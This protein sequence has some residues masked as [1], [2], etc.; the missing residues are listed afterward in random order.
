M[1]EH[2]KM[3]VVVMTE[4]EDGNGDVMRRLRRRSMAKT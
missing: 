2:C 1:A 4:G 3:K